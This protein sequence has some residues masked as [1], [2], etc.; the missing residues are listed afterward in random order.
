[1]TEPLT[2]E[3]M[4]AA[5]IAKLQRP[6]VAPLVW[7]ARNDRVTAE[8]FGVREFYGVRGNPGAWSLISPGPD[9]YV[10]T[11][12]YQTQAGAKAAAQVDYERRVM[13]ALDPR[14]PS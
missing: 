3:A 1:M 7:I 10:E 2:E 14:D 5:T 9:K 12:G 6:K 8:A 11:P 4:A 13:A